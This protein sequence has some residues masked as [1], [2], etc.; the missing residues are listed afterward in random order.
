MKLSTLLFFCF[1][2]LFNVVLQAK[3]NVHLNPPPVDSLLNDVRSGTS[4]LPAPGMELPKA[5]PAVLDGQAHVLAPTV[6]VVGDFCGQG[7]GFIDL[8]PDPN[9][10]GPWT[11]LW[12]NG[13]TTEDLTGLSAGTYGVIVT[14]ANGVPQATVVVVNDLPPASPTGAVAIM[15]GNSVCSAPYNGALEVIVAP[16][17][18]WTFLWSTGETSNIATGLNSGT[19]TVSITFGVTCTTPYEF[20]VPDNANSPITSIPPPGFAPSTCERSDGATGVLV[21]GGVTPYTYLWSNGATTVGNNNIPAGTYTVTV[22]GANGCTSTESVTVDNINYNMFIEDES[23]IIIPNTTCIGANGSIDLGI[24]HPIAQQPFTYLWSNGATTQDLT[25]LESGSYRVTVSI[26]DACFVTEVYYVE[27][28]P[29]IPTLTSTNTPTTCGFSNGFVNLTVLNGGLPPFTYLWSNGATTQDLMNVPADYYEVTVTGINGC[30]AT[31]GASIDDNQVIFN[32]SAQVTDQFA[33]DTSNGKIALSLFPSSLTVLW[34]NGATTNNLNNIAPGNY[35]VTI[36]AGGTC[37]AVETYSVG[38]V[39]DYPSIPAAATNTTCGLSNGSINLTVN[40][41]E[42]PFT[43]QWSNGATTQDLANLQADTF[44]V[45]VTSSVGC[46]AENQVIVPNLNAGIAID[47]MVQP[48]ISCGTPNG[49]IS[50]NVTP[51]DTAY[52]YLWSSGQTTDS[53]GN[54]LSGTY[55]VTVT[56]GNTCIAMD[57]FTIQNDAFPP[58]LSVTGNS[59]NCGLS[60][61]SA[62]LSL[63]GGT[64]PFSYQWTNLATTEDLSNLP[65]GNY[66]VTVTGANACTAQA[67]V[68]IPNN[69][70]ALNLSATP[71]GNAS[72]TAANGAIDLTVSPT[73]VYTYLWSNA[74]ATEDLSNLNSGTYTVTVSLGSCQSSTTFS[75]EDNTATPVINSNI[76][77]S[78]CSIDNGSIDLSITGTAGP[79]TYQWSNMA[80]TEDL[81]NIFPG[82]YS[83]TVSAANGC[84]QMANLN[85][86][87]NASNF[88]LAAAPAPTTDCATNNGSIDL[89]VTP[90]GSFTFLW[91]TNATTEDLSGLAPGAYTVSVTQSG[92]CTATASYFVIDQRT[93]PIANQAVVAEFCGQS[94]GSIDLSVNAGTP[95]YNYLWNGA[96]ITEDLSGIPAGTYTVTIT[97]LNHCTVTSSVVVP[98]NTVSFALSGGIG[99]NSSCISNNGSIDLEVNPPGSFAYAWSNLANTEDLSGLNAGTYTVTVSAGGNCTNTAVFNIIN[100]L[101]SP[102]LLQNIVPD[103]CAQSTGSID[104]GVSGSPAPYT[105]T[106]STGATDEDINGL[107]S[108]NYSV[109]VTAANGCTSVQNIQV[110]ETTFTPAIVSQTNPASSCVL[111]NGSIDLSVSPAQAYSYLWSNTA[112]TEDLSN[113]APGNYTVTVSAGGACSNTAVVTVGSNIPLPV[114]ANTQIAATCGQASGS[115]DL[116]VSGSPAPYNFAWSNA[117]NTEDLSAL[118]SG[119]YTVTVTDANSCTSTLQ[120]TVQE[121]VFIP[122]IAPQLTQVSSCTV[123]NGA[124]D[125]LITP[126]GAYTFLWSNLAITEDLN[127][128]AAGSY[129]VTV[130][131]G[132]GCT[133]TVSLVLN[134]IALQPALTNAVTAATCGQ[135]SG[136]LDLSVSGA[137]GP[138]NYSWSNAAIVEDLTGIPSGSYTVTVTA[139][140]NCTTTGSF[141]VPEN[142]LIPVLSGIPAPASSCLADIGAIDLSVSPPSSVGYT[143]LWSNNSNQEDLSN[144]APGIYTVTV[145]GGGACINSASFTIADQTT[146]PVANIATGLSTLDCINTSTSLQGSMSGTNNPGSFIWLNN[147]VPVGNSNTL[148]VNTPGQYFLIT[149]DNVSSCADTSSISIA[150]N[151]NPPTISIANPAVLTCSVPTQTLSGSATL[152][153]IQFAWAT[154]NGLDTTMVGTGANLPVSGAGTYFLFG[155]NPANQCSN[156]VSVTVTANQ[157][158]PVADAGNPFTLDC[159][160]E[161]AGLNGSGAGAGNLLYQWST[162]DGHFVSGVNTAN[163]FIDESGT[164]EL[165]VTNTSNGC[166]AVDAVTIEPEIPVAYATIIQ[167]TCLEPEGSILIDSITGLSAPILFSLNNG[168]SG[169]QDQFDHLAPGNYQISVLGDNGCMAL[170][171]ASIEAP[172]V[173]TVHLEPSAT[174]NLGYSYLLEAMVNVPDADLT[175][176]TWTPSTALACDSCLS[177]LA[178]PFS[179]TDYEIHVVD[180]DGCEARGSLVLRVDKTRRIYAPNIFSPDD[181]GSNDFFTIFADPVAVVKIQS[182]QVFSRWGA[183]IFERNDFIAGAQELGWDGTYRGQKLNPAV[184]VWQAVVLFIDGKEEL[185]TGDVTLQR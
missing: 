171:E 140:N 20:T 30:T 91:S 76:T 181:D 106:W 99:S 52:T 73:G 61:G 125:L 170:V 128:L 79:F 113:L 139:S 50:L 105:F 126:A 177:T 147:G 157:T 179:T 124:I 74:A 68:N 167:P 65:P 101:P 130:S 77:A 1:L 162:Q 114:L 146:Q 109:L 63:S 9:T 53:L 81:A 156:G 42:P 2:P 88:S 48:N 93:N 40:G 78:I 110:T 145:N 18:P 148:V 70:I 67:S 11:F 175:S 46:S 141:S 29:V 49:S 169:L 151:V 115:I 60:D 13:E 35:T 164:Y 22:T 34:S 21:A 45:T 96:Q 72:C 100:D 155:L 87:N 121:A 98:G 132:G 89:N 127:N 133:N 84:T 122:G 69:N 137:P 176:I 135:S 184:F 180:K 118:V 85:V 33:C 43:Y 131:A 47:E 161:T 150:Q 82:N 59:A 112:N 86:A 119:N 116:S 174:I 94:D 178:T 31:A 143:Y 27:D 38:D 120:V 36:S 160:G 15:T 55:L 168:Q 26:N 111:Q 62:D 136:N 152:P 144:L 10:P 165:V 142:T 158:P 57:T 19:Y 25:N 51:I 173:L 32:Y 163:P 129:T 4:I 123:N 41:G 8:T 92:S 102:V 104:L 182:L 154:I 56:L 64:G 97:D 5:D 83:V 153:G 95:P 6:V 138:Y 117:A 37:T 3:S 28:A 23:V 54:L 24:I 58:N 183:Q 66:L 14:D 185:F 75:V 172:E 103:F 149:L 39:T 134:N 90:A 16:M 17:G 166:T 12:S 7:T 80:T 44:Y 71:L 108:G 159:A 107:L